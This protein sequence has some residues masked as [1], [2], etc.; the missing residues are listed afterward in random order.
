M[1]Y[2]QLALAYGRTGG[3][4]VLPITE[5]VR[6]NLQSEFLNVFKH[7]TFGWRGNLSSQN[8]VQASNFGTGLLNTGIAGGG[9]RQ[10]DF[11]A[12]ILF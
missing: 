1:G 4:D 5:R 9:N 3:R 7:S 12:N 10:I 2:Y 8:N 6:F 11:R